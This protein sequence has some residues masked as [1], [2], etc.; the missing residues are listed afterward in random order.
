[1]AGLPLG[2]AFWVFSS[3]AFALPYWLYKPITNRL[4]KHPAIAA[5]LATLITSG[6]ST[7][8]PPLGLIGWTSPWIGAINEGWFG[9]VWVLL[10]ILLIAYLAAKDNDASVPP[11]VIL[12]ALLLALPF[13]GAFT[14]PRLYP[15]AGWTAISTHGGHL[16]AVSSIEESERIVPKVLSDLHQ[17]KVV[18]LP[19]TIAGYFGPGTK[20]IWRPVI[21]YSKTNSD[22]TV[23]LGAAVPHGVTLSDDLV[24]IHQGRLSYLPDRIPV[25]FSM[26]HPWHPNGSFAMRVLGK[27]E[28]STIAGVRAG[29]LICYEQLL[30]WPALSLIHQH[31]QVLLAPANDWWAQGTD[32]PAIQRV[33]A[34][35]W[36]HLLGVPVLVAVN[37]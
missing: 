20:A 37:K 26:W 28:I 19:E 23:L 17:N 35:A 6:L 16:T 27:P 18:L 33:S 2:I 24:A 14:L 15:P 32:I 7:V 1:Y 36:G 10:S 11:L 4:P 34:K 29:Y 9:L 5:L 3:L 13:I 12:P 30:I 25:P 22:K 8:L 31:I 21:Q